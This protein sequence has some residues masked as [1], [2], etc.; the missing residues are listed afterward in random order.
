METRSIRN[1]LFD[2]LIGT[3]W[4]NQLRFF[5]KSGDFEAIIDFLKHEVDDHRRFTPPIKDWFRPFQLSNFDQ[6]KVVFLVS[7]GT[8]DPTLDN[9]LAISCNESIRPSIQFYR[10]RAELAAQYPNH[11]LTTGKMSHIANQGVLLLNCSI[12]SQINKLGTH[13]NLWKPFLL[14]VIE[15]LNK[16]KD[17]IWVIFGENEL[18]RYVNKSHHILNI[19]ELPTHP[20]IKWSSEN[21]F[22]R[23]NEQLKLKNKSEIIW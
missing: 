9:G 12:T 18:Q 11:S 13:Q 15:V 23:I 20:D 3:D 16:K 19:K 8:G 2:K 7:E 22:L 10:F 6:T 14:Y 4:D 21:F 17:L 5:I 1:S